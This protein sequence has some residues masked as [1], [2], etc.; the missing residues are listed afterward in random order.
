MNFNI[1]KFNIITPK[2]T[3]RSNENKAFNTQP[4]T[5]PIPNDSFEMSVGY[6]NDTHGHTNNMM[7][8]LSGIKG[9][10]RLSGGDNDIGDEKNQGVRQATTK[11]LNI[12]GIHATA[13]GNHELD[14]TQKDCI[15]AIKKFNGEFLSI[16]YKKDA[17]Q[18]CQ[19]S[20]FMSYRRMEDTRL[21]RSFATPRII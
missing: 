3:F 5:K 2:I 9:D 19:A 21:S 20:F 7:R 4:A 13:L 1:P 14:T 18:N 6:I 10:L 12:A 17:W 15:E 16:N 8:I 11:F